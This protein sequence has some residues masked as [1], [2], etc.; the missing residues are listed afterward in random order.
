MFPSSLGECSAHRIDTP[1][2]EEQK[3]HW[4][5]YSFLSSFF[6]SLKEITNW[7]KICKDKQ[8]AI[9]V[10]RKERKRAWCIYMEPK[11]PWLN[12]L[13]STLHALLSYKSHSWT[14]NLKNK[15]E[16]RTFQGQEQKVTA[17]ES[18]MSRIVNNFRDKNEHTG[19]WIENSKSHIKH[20]GPCFSN[21]WDV[22]SWICLYWDHVN[23]MLEN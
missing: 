14:K 11:G 1:S 18:K 23:H 15:S 17:Q 5:T 3:S 20:I 8:E 9:D 16:Q 4:P 12:F 13:Y 6:L 21:L 2:V 22:T 10:V 19:S 7:Q